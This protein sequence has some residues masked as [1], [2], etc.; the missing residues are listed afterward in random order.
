MHQK[1]CEVIGIIELPKIN[2]DCFRHRRIYM[3]TKQIISIALMLALL[4]TASSGCGTKESASPNNKE[5]STSVISSET[6]EIK[7]NEESKSTSTPAAEKK[8]HS[9]YVKTYSVYAEQGAVVTWFD[10][11]TG[12]F[13]YKDKCETCGQVASGEHSGGLFVGEGSSYNAGFTC[14]NSNCSMWGKPQRAIISCST[15][16]EWIE[17]DD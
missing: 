1:W 15:S 7:E 10:P 9:E 11:K 17:V 6:S 16:G 8:T 12:Q 2:A 5:E 14:T 13:R 4:V 3:K